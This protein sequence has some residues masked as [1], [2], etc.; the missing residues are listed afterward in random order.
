MSE[1][2]T[3]LGPYNGPNYAGFIFTLISADGSPTHL[4]AISTQVPEVSHYQAYIQGTWQGENPAGGGSPKPVSGLI[5]ADGAGIQCS[6]TT[7]NGINVLKG[8]LTYS[9]GRFGDSGTHIGFVPPEAYL[10]GAVTAY[11]SNG[12]VLPGGPGNVSGSGWSGA[13]IVR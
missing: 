3:R 12:K 4:L 2:G 11:D 10:D 13:H 5:T 9:P 7:P 8:T 1:F 6:W